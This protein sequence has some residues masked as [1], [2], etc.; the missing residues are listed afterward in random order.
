LRQDFLKPQSFPWGRGL[1]SWA[2]A[3]LGEGA[4]AVAPLSTLPPRATCDLMDGV[5]QWA[6]NCSG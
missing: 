2:A 3:R 6:T 1:R 5:G 4:C